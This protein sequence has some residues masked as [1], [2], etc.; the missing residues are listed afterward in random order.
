MLNVH[1]KILHSNSSF[2]QIVANFAKSKGMNIKT[3]KSTAQAEFNQL[4]FANNANNCGIV[5]EILNFC[6]NIY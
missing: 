2:C 6:I 1:I 4:K 3:S 5:H